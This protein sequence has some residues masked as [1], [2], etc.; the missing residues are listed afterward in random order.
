MVEPVPQENPEQ[1]DAEESSGE[2]V[3]MEEYLLYSAR[4]GEIEGIQEC[5]DAQ[6]A[7]DYQNEDMGNS[8]LHFATANGHL[9]CIAK[10]LEHGANINL[11][12]KS[13]NTA[14]HWAGLCG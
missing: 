5:M 10:L 6:V 11:Q 2:E 9:A 4:A 12:N 14:L 8:A 13:K 3:T 1:N 7:I